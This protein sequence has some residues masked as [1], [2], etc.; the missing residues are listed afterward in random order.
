MPNE[1]TEKLVLIVDDSKDI[2]DVFGRFLREEGFRVASA[3]DGQEALEEA[4]KLQPDLILMDLSL[5]GIGGRAATQR[6]KNNKKT[7]HIP[8]VILTAHSSDGV[9]TVTKEGCAG[10]LIK[11]CIPEELLKEVVRALQHRSA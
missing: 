3:T 4:V 11:T 5:P 1:N 6:L 10:F 2:R 9:A 7:R 8:V